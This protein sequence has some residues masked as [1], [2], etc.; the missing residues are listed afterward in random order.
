MT[1][2]ARQRPNSAKRGHVLDPNGCVD[3]PPQPCGDC[4]K[5]GAAGSFFLFYFRTSPSP[6]SD[7][8]DDLDSMR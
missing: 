7:G 3:A 6:R 5:G 2:D 8:D 1:Q 4:G